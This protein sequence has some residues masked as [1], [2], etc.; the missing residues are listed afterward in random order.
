M[1][2]YFIL[3]RFIIRGVKVSGFEKCLLSIKLFGHF[4]EIIE[5]KKK[6][7]IRERRQ[8]DV[9]DLLP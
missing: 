8:L 4:I 7:T 9:C 6:E 3:F 5:G 2:F 1:S